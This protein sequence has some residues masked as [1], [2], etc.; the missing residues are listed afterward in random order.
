MTAWRQP[1]KLDEGL[2]REQIRRRGLK[3]QGSRKRN[4]LELAP[5]TADELRRSEHI[6]AARTRAG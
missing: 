3:A 4:K 2:D 5:L 1:I 6:L